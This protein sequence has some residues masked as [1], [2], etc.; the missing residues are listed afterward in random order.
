MFDP[1]GGPVIGVDF[2]TRSCSVAVLDGNGDAVLIPNAEG[3]TLTPCVVA[4]TADGATL[5]GAVAQRQAAANPRYTMPV[6]VQAGSAPT[7]P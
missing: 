7:G 3:A 5:V 6:S 4:V 2:G 1:G